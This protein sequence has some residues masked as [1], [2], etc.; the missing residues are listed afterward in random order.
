M[1]GCGKLANHGS[2]VNS[3]AKDTGSEGVSTH[4]L[5]SNTPA[6][7][8]EPS[9]SALPASDSAASSSWISWHWGFPTINI[10][11]SI[12]KYAV[13]ICLYALA[14][15]AV[16]YGVYKPLYRFADFSP[17]SID[18]LQLVEGMPEGYKQCYLSPPK[19]CKKDYLELD[20]G[21][22]FDRDT[23]EFVEEIPVQEAGYNPNTFFTAYYYKPNS[24]KPNLLK[25]L[26]RKIFRIKI[27]QDYCYTGE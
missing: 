16:Y 15:Y 11:N 25:T 3:V 20:E 2:P 26:L 13:N 24:S 27:P 7:T 14:V 22:F 10:N 8:P 21:H 19:D 5:T 12:I 6:P 23:R 1:P 4:S 9:K 17:I 18:K